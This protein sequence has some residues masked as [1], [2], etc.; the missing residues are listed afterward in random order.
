MFEKNPK[1]ETVSILKSADHSY[2]DGLHAAA[3]QAGESMRGMYN[4]ASHELSH[5]GDRVK[6]E[7]RSNPIRSSA[8]ALGV[9]ALIGLLVRR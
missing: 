9:G 7:I 6:A 4:S 2:S 1:N 8:I 5:A 3:H